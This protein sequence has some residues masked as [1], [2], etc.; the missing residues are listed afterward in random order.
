MLNFCEESFIAARQA[1]DPCVLSLLHEHCCTSN[2]A[3]AQLDLRVATQ[4]NTTREDK[5]AIS[6]PKQVIR[7]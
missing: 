6:L 7:T 4:F 5:I 2:A 3:I 1:A